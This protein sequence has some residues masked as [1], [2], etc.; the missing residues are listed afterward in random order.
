MSANDDEVDA[1][2]GD[3]DSDDEPQ[4]PPPPQRE[5]L[6]RG[7][8]RVA[9][10][11]EDEGAGAFVPRPVTR[12]RAAPPPPTPALAAPSVLRAERVPVAGACCTAPPPRERRA[13]PRPAERA[14]LP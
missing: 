5:Q 3:T 14:R 4:Q 11:P 1:L 6:A 7:P 2:F 8:E 13:A 12:G 10:Q 9:Q